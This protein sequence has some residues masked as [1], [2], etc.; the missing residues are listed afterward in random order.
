MSCTVCVNSFQYMVWLLEVLQDTDS[1]KMTNFGMRKLRDCLQLAAIVDGFVLQLLFHDLDSAV[2]AARQL[3]QPDCAI[4][5]LAQTVDSV[6]KLLFSDF[7][8]ASAATGHFNDM[9]CR[10]AGNSC[11]KFRISDQV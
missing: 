1:N 11:I 3:L 8:L 4:S 9:S 6:P 5:A 7:S 2:F 10:V